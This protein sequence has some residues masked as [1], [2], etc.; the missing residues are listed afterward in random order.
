MDTST[1]RGAQ[2]TVLCPQFL[3][4][5]ERRH[6]LHHHIQHVNKLLGL[7]TAAQA[8]DASSQQP[9]TQKNIA[10]FDSIDARDVLKVDN[11]G[12]LAA[13]SALLEHLDTVRV[14]LDVFNL[15]EP[16]S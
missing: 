5:P 12:V 1:R 7:R 8:K 2:D 3:P 13:E 15:P 10:A 6:R 11:L 16:L 9:V 14:D 4:W